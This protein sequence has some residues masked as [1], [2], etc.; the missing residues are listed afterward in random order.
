[1]SDPLQPAELRHRATLGIL[2]VLSSYHY[3]V[4]FS[5]RGLL[6]ERDPYLSLL[7]EIGH[8]V[9]QFSFSSSRD[10]ISARIEPHAPR[11]TKLLRIAEKL[12]SEGIHVT[13]RW[14]PY[15]PGV[16]ESP[17]I[18]VGRAASAGFSHIGLEHLKLPVERN[19]PLWATFLAGTQRDLYAEYQAW[20]AHRD[21]REYV[22]PAGRKLPTIIEVASL[23]KSCGLTF[24]AADNEFQYL[25]DTACCCSGVDQFP[26]F[27]NWFKYQIGYAIWK[28]RDL[29][30]IELRAIA[31]EWH[32]SGSVDR[33]LNSHSRL[34]HRGTA[35]GSVR[36]HIT[37]R[38]RDISSPN[39]PSTFYGVVAAQQYQGR[40]RA[41]VWTEEARSLLRER[42][43]RDK[44]KT[45]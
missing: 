1:M 33:F 11:P 37:E 4:V 26:G 36:A 29:D 5:T 15:I 19:H 21:G 32:P 43:L 22:L 30:R 13:C 34:T 3:P 44:S 16:S 42:A 31:K 28:A 14:Q 35:K 17:A 7:K 2:R 45:C 10:E 39:N 38:W 6:L 25:S 27:E 9:V 20:G 24:G 18:F 12:A 8:V 23:A 40:S 41:Y